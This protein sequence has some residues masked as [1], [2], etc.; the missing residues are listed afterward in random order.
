VTEFV[1]R[2]AP[3]GAGAKTLLLL[4]GTGGDEESLMELG[5]AVAPSW[6]L[7][8]VR[9][10]S[11][12]EGVPRFFRRLAEGVLDEEDIVFRAGELSAFLEWAS[13]EYGFESG[14]LVALGYSNGANMAA[15]MLML[16][17]DLLSA[18]ALLRPMVPLRPSD[19]PDL[20]GK[21]ALILSGQ[22]DAM[23]PAT[24]GWALSALLEEY[25]ATVR[26]EVLP[27]GH[28]LTGSD[29]EMARDWLKEL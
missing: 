11:L 20:R 23:V 13:A 9:G 19:P 29:M 28:G 14:S 27:S 26:S 25:G 8:G 18:A 15:T 24:Q 12:E 22:M 2:F 5:E 4:H 6:S 16:Q 1:H 21:K 17:P 10:R 7:L 3:G